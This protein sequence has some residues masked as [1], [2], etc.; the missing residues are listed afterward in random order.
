MRKVYSA[1]SSECQGSHISPDQISQLIE[2]VTVP[3]H[4]ASFHT[5]LIIAHAAFLI[6]D[7]V[8]QLF[9][10]LQSYFPISPS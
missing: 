9:T 1:L 6:H 8:C 10:P 5:Y 3:Y 7:C 2:S 4:T